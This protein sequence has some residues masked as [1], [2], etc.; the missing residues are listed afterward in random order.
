MEEIIIPK[1]IIG[2]ILQA[3][4][5]IQNGRTHHNVLTQLV[6]EVGELSTEIAISDGFS[7]KQKVLMV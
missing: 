6:E 7:K 3:G 4:Q 2:E 1:G 5:R